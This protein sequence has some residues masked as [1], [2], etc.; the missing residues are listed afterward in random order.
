MVKLTNENR[1][2]QEIGNLAAN[3]KIRDSGALTT[4]TNGSKLTAQDAKTK[5]QKKL[6]PTIRQRIN[7]VKFYLNLMANMNY[8]PYLEDLSSLPKEQKPLINFWDSALHVQIDLLNR[9]T[10]PL[11]VFIVLNGFFSNLVSSEDCVAKIINIVYDLLQDDRQGYRIRRELENKIPNG[12]LTAHLRTFHAIGE[13]GKPDK[14]GSTFNIAK[15]IRNQLVHDDIAEVMFFPTLSLLGL[16]DRD[17]YFNNVFFPAY[18]PPKHNNTGMITF[19]KNVYNET[20]S[21]VDK[22]YRLIYTDLQ[23]SGVLPVD[24]KI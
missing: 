2:L 11:I 14:T 17:L 21:F 7:A 18:T 16:S 13:D 1:L 24:S 5:I 8:A 6:I 20:V 9:D 3:G 22:C 10:F 12:I 23:Q 15:K 4:K 19:C